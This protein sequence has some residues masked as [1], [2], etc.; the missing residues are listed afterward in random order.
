MTNQEI[1]LRLVEAFIKDGRIRQGYNFDYITTEINRLVDYIN[2]D[3]P[4]DIFKTYNVKLGEDRKNELSEEEKL[5]KIYFDFYDKME[6]PERSEA[7]EN[8]NY[9][10]AKKFNNPENLYWALNKGFEFD[11]NGN[12]WRN[13]QKKY[14]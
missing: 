1:K 4:E 14:S 7:K 10:Y 2:K 6:E 8:W 3:N 9:E 5:R 11:G 12:Y 13:I